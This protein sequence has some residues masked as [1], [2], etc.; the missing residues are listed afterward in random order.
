[1]ICSKGQL[2][3]L[4]E[5]SRLIMAELNGDADGTAIIDCIIYPE[6]P[7]GQRGV[8][9][10]TPICGSHWWTEPELEAAT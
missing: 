6:Q 9:L 8:R 3:T 7:E 10:K 1:M 2:V 4:T 5:R